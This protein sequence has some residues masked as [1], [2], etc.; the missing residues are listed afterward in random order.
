MIIIVLDYCSG[1]VLKFILT[2]V[3]TVIYKRDPDEYISQLYDE[4]NL[5]ESDCEYMAVEEYKEEMHFVK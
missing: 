3:E 2:D 4:Y 1:T 5:R